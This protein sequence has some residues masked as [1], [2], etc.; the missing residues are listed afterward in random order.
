[1]R[2]RLT[3]TRP[4]PRA[5]LASEELTARPPDHAQE[6]ERRVRKSVEEQLGL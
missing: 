3:L 4:V 5:R 1:M 2:P 6:Y